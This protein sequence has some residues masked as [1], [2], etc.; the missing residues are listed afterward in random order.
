MLGISYGVQVISY[1]L[2][3]QIPFTPITVRLIVTLAALCYGI[4][5]R[6]EIQAKM[7]NTQ[8]AIHNRMTFFQKLDKLDG[9][10]KLRYMQERSRLKKQHRQKVRQSMM[11]V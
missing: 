3:L 11:V 7:K 2:A 6:E 9:L 8:E 5:H 10:E 1:I 4:A